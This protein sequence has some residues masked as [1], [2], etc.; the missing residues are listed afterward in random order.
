MSSSLQA[1]SSI[2]SDQYCVFVETT[3]PLATHMGSVCREDPVRVRCMDQEVM[4]ICLSGISGISYQMKNVRRSRTQRTRSHGKRCSFRVILIPNRSPRKTKTG[5]RCRQSGCA[6]ILREM[7]GYDDARH[8]R[9][10]NRY[11]GRME[12][13]ER[14]VAHVIGSEAREAFT[15]LKNLILQE[16]Q[17]LLQAGKNEFYKA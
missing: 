8:S 16:H 4:I 9:Y 12:E 15:W 14:R 10:Q 11:E 17:V 6:G 5:K 3:N 1:L 13:D 2:P 7:R